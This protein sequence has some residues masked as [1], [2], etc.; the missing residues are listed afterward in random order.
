MTTT[1]IIIIIIT[2]VNS[3]R[4]DETGR[5]E[6]GNNKDEKASDIDSDIKLVTLTY[7]VQQHKHNVQMHSVTLLLLKP[8]NNKTGDRKAESNYSPE[9]LDKGA[10]SDILS[11]PSGTSR[12]RNSLLATTKRTQF[13]SK[14]LLKE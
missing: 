3:R 6:V 4:N 14:E 11:L 10:T 9:I 12:A 1:V 13:Q 2:D 5:L 7:R 8:P